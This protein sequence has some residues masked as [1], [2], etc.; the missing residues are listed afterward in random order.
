MDFLR[1]YRPSPAP[2][3]LNQLFKELIKLLV[4][5]LIKHLIKQRGQ[6]D[7]L[8]ADHLADQLLIKLSFRWLIK[9]LIKQRVTTLI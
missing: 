9:H 4:R 8:T 3:I 5:W 1:E 2:Y 6:K 7:Y